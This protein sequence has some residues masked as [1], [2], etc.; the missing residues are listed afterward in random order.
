MAPAPRERIVIVGG[1]I[2]ALTAAYYLSHSPA[3]RARY[4]VTLYQMG[5][6]LGGKLASGR[7]GPH[8]RSVEHGLHVWFGFYDNAFRLA[9]ATYARWARPHGCPFASWQ[10]AFEPQSFTPIGENIDGTWSTWPLHWPTNEDIPGSGEVFLSPWGAITQFLGSIIAMVETLVAEHGLSLGPDLP[11]AVPDWLEGIVN[12]GFELLADNHV[13]SRQFVSLLQRA[14]AVAA[15]LADEDANG[16]PDAVDDAATF[17]SDLLDRFG[18]LLVQQ[19]DDLDDDRIDTHHIL[20]AIDI[21]IAVCR[22]LLNPEYS[23]LADGNLDK[24]DPLEFRQFLKD[25][26]ANPDIVDHWSV[27]RALYDTTFQYIDGDTSRPTFAAGCAL[28]VIIR[29]LFTYKGAVLYLV[30]SGMGETLIAPLYDVLRDQGVRFEFF[31][32]LTHLGLSPDTNVLNTLTLAKQVRTVD[33]APYAPLFN[34]KGLRCWPD[35]PFW[36]QLQ[37]GQDMKDAGV[38]W[39][40]H[41]N[42]W[43][44][45]ENVTLEQGTDFDR[46]ILGVSMGAF[47]TLNSQ[48]P[49]LASELLAHKPALKTMTEQLPLV[50]NVGAQFWMDRTLPE[51]GWDLGRP[52]MVGWTYP[53]NIWADMTPVI[54]T[55]DWPEGDAPKTVHYLTGTLGTTLYRAPSSQTDAP[56]LARQQFVA[57]TREQFERYARSIWPKA[58]TPGTDALDYAVLHAPA[59]TT[60]LERFEAQYFRSNINPT[61]CIVGTPANSTRFRIEP[62]QTGIVNLV[63]CGAW[64]K[65]GIDASCVEGAVISGMK[66]ARAITREPL[67]IVGEYFLGPQ[68]S[69][70][71]ASIPGFPPIAPA[72]P[73]LST[74]PVPPTP[75]ASPETMTELPPYQNTL[76]HGQQS[77]LPP[78]LVYDAHVSTFGVKIDA[79]RAETF[80]N[81]R[82][83]G[84][85]LGEVEYKVLGDLALVSF[86]D[87]KLTSTAV[88]MGWVGD[89]EC[90]I[91]LLLAEKRAGSNDV[92][93]V[94]WMPY[95]FVDTSIAMCTGREIWGFAKEIGQITVPDPDAPQDHFAATARLFSTLDEA[96]EG[97]VETV[98][99]VTRNTNAGPIESIWDDLGQ[100]TTWLFDQLTNGDNHLWH[101][102]DALEIAVDAAE[103]ALKNQVWI[104]NLKQFRDAEFPT[105]S[106]YSAIIH[107]PFDIQTVHEGGLLIGEYT[108]KIADSQS[109]Q[110]VTDL[111]LPSHEVPVMFG[112]W[113]KMDFLVQPGKAI[114]SAG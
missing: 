109:H 61:E 50:P 21:G 83:A 112:F 11:D 10:D 68:P 8:A 76:G 57:R 75:S 78:G 24:L 105:R 95:I 54:A 86:L 53:N 18:N 45:A 84:P 65:T 82:L 16:V 111:G 96:T 12:R 47:K 59:G 74:E 77:V 104:T 92:K 56:A 85:T 20:N 29:I 31:H 87:A 1:G 90:A 52:A 80:V 28:R 71:P 3:M 42:T 32:K 6:R 35:E 15:S 99:S 91:T 9:Q 58:V 23:L 7:Q 67:D 66:A 46:C 39:E 110:I 17:V 2:A 33:N 64:T 60:G 81:Q 88:Q 5:W 43:P 79:Q 106:C 72:P 107:S 34:V 100:I 41:W 89:H 108:L 113:V 51:L 93:L 102:D 103:I 98:V 26:G 40:S 19:A 73:V 48:D 49:N 101:W 36:D 13:I 114:W 70:A 4:E 14:R 44:T 38:D 55:E 63:V 30:Q 94:A 25:N 69:P 27:L 22:G 37:D 97:V 62:H